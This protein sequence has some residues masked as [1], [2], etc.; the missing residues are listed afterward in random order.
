MCANRVERIPCIAG[1]AAGRNV[2]NRGA[3]RPSAE[4]PHRLVQ[5]LYGELEQV[6]K[7]EHA[8]IAWPTARKPSAANSRPPPVP[9]PPTPLTCREADRC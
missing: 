5:E 4:S 8:R 1:K 2:F 7:F 6:S 9:L 3:Q